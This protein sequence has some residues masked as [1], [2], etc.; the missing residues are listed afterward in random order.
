V[1]LYWLT[2]LVMFLVV[3]WA[4]THRL[5]RFWVPTIPIMALLAAGGATWSSAWS[6]QRAASIVLGVGLVANFIF[7]V[8]PRPQIAD[9][10]YFVSLEQLRDDPR[11]T[12][13]P[14]AY[15]PVAFRYLDEHVPAGA[16]ALVVGNAAVFPLQVPVLYNTCFDDCTFENLFRDRTAQQRRTLLAELGISHIYIDWAELERYR[17]PGNYG[18][19]PYA[20]RELVH[21]ELVAQQQLLR[22]VSVPGLEPELGELFEV[23]P[24]SDG[25]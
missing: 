10:R 20:T 3:W 9:N 2:L 5:E 7:M 22:P 25:W 4:A 11:M 1:Q 14:G 12:F 18:Y 24:S 23:V 17:Q 8:A 16:R 15:A 19:S 6:W 13:P 21:G